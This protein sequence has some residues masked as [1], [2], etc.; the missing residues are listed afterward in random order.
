MATLHVEIKELPQTVRDVLKE[1]KYGKRDIAVD[2]GTSFSIADSG[3][4]GERAFWCIVNIATGQHHVEWGSWGGSNMFNPRNPVDLDNRPKP[5]PPGAVVIKGHI[6]DGPTYARII[7]HPENVKLLAA[8]KDESEALTEAEQKALNVIG[9]IKSGYRA[10]EFR[11]QGLGS[12]GPANPVIQSL[13]AKGMISVTGVGISITTKGKG[14]RVNRFASRVAARYLCKTAYT[15]VGQKIT[16]GTVTFK[17]E[18]LVKKPG[19]REVTGLLGTKTP[20]GES[21]EVSLTLFLVP[22]P[23]P[24]QYLSWVLH[25]VV[26]P[27]V[28]NSGILLMLESFAAN[29]APALAGLND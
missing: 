12:Y 10:D 15:A 19:I 24:R 9:G 18:S 6:G 22:H 11:H 29:I 5:L 13:A 17:E 7:A 20:R 3:G 28:T 14:S 16:F 8:P 1:L 21:I 27:G 2:V 4:S 23:D 26:V 25:H